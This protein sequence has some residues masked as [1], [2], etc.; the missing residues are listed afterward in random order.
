MQHFKP[1]K[2]VDMFLRNT[3][4]AAVL[5]AAGISPALA[6]H[7]S[8]TFDMDADGEV[9]IA[10][11]GHVSDYLLKSKLSKPLTVLID[12][13]VR[14]WLFEPILV[15]GKPVIAKTAI[16][17]RL[18]GVPTS[19]DNYAVKIVEIN[20]GEPKRTGNIEPPK[21]PM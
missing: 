5:M 18:E 20:F 4:L 19:G 12:R 9:Q 7:S 3:K 15:D 6:Q 17:L 2:G 13:A 16:H 14:S 8:P 1:G 10:P 21:Y 11:D